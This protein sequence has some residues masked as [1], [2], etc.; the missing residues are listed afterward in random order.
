MSVEC[1]C[2][3]HTDTLY[4]LRC[5]YVGERKK[6]AK[7]FNH[8]YI[9]MERIGDGF[10]LSMFNWH[11]RTKY[12]NVTTNWIY[13]GVLYTFTTHTHTYSC[14]P[15]QCPVFSFGSI[16]Y[17]FT[18]PWFT[19]VVYIHLYI[20]YYYIYTYIDKRCRAELK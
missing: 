15:N 10:V 11:N 3:E 16:I 18:L 6:K 13:H 7:I 14:L 5:V 1:K 12:Y 4:I 9:T 17:I 8:I 20:F 2:M 19:H